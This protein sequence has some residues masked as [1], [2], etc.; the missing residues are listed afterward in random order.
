MRTPRP[1][2]I[3]ATFSL[4]ALF[5]VSDLPSG[6]GEVSAHPPSPSSSSADL[7]ALRSCESGG[8]YRAN[9][10]NGYYGAYQFS[11]ST[12]QSLGHGGRASDAAPHV[13]DE[14]ALRLASTKGWSQ[15][16]ACARSLGLKGTAAPPATG[17]AAVTTTPPAPVAEPTPAPVSG[18]NAG[19]EFIRWARSA[20]ASAPA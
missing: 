18:R 4:A 12:W 6:P 15:W 9:T 13:Q 19:R 17:V 16:P 11:P 1:A 20:P 2:A 10:G 8:N 3:A 7:A 5:A 14:A